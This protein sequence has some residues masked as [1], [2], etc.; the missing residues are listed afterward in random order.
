MESRHAGRPERW[1]KIQTGKNPASK[2]S[3]GQRREPS[4]H[5]RISA[6]PAF[7]SSLSNFPRSDT[8]TG[9]RDQFLAAE[10]HQHQRLIEAEMPTKANFQVTGGAQVGATTGTDTDPHGACHGLTL[11]FV[12]PD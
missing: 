9:K 5:S 7:L 1:E 2:A 6:L 4:D 10:V 8:G 11:P 12:D 3:T